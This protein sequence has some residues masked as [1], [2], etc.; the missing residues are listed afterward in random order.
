MG[1]RRMS[2][3]ITKAV[4]LDNDVIKLVEDVAKMYGGNFSFTVEL[5]L[6]IA[7]NYY[8]AYLNKDNG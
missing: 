6:K 1:G 5:L 2:K 3:R 8:L 4:S 7:I